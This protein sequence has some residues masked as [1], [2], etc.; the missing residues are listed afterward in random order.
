MSDRVW[1]YV[2]DEGNMIVFSGEPFVNQGEEHFIKGYIDEYPFTIEAEDEAMTMNILN[3]S[4]IPFDHEIAKYVV[5]HI[6]TV[7]G[8]ESKAKK[9]GE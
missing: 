7:R 6:I 1:F 5:K 9:E 8:L 3:Y 4:A 2:D